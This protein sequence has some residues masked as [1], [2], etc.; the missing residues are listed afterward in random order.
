MPNGYRKNFKGISR[1]KKLGTLQSHSLVG[2]II[3]LEKTVGYVA[4]TTVRNTYWV[5]SLRKS[6]NR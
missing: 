3:S 1:K 4:T 2:Q 6:V 5:L